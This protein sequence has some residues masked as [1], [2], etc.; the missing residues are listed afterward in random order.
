MAVLKVYGHSDDCV[1]IEGDIQE[2]WYSKPMNFLFFSDGTILQMYYNDY[3][4]WV[5]FVRNQGSASIEKIESSDDEENYSDVV[6]LY[7]DIRWVGFGIAFY[8]GAEQAVL[9]VFNKHQIYFKEGS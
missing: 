6:T 1:K 7:G 5:I 9:E 2:E 4:R 8:E 3:G